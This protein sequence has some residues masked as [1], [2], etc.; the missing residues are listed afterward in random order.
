[1]TTYD[2]VAHCYDRSTYDTINH[3]IRAYDELKHI[4]YWC[5]TLCSLLVFFFFF[6]ST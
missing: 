3:D 4:W 1:M 6:F 5:Y 2:F